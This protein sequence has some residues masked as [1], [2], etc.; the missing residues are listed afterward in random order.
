MTGAYTAAEERYTDVDAAY[1][2]LLQAADAARTVHDPQAARRATET[3]RGAE[4]RVVSRLTQVEEQVTE[5]ERRART[6]RD[7]A[8]ERGNIVRGTT[9]GD[10]VVVATGTLVTGEID[11]AYPHGGLQVRAERHYRSGT[12][13]TGSFGIWIWPFDSRIIRGV[14]PGIEE[15]ASEAS[16]ALA[17]IEEALERASEAAG[18]AFGENLLDAPQETLEG[19][20]ELV[21]SGR[22]LKAEAESAYREAEQSAD[23]AATLAASHADWSASP[24]YACLEE[25]ASELRRRIRGWTERLEDTEQ[26]AKETT[27]LLSALEGLLEEATVLTGTLRSAA[28]LSLVAREANRH[29]LFPADPVSLEETGAGTLVLVDET[30][31]PQLFRITS[32]PHPSSSEN[33]YPGGA[34]AEPVS[35]AL[36]GKEE[37]RIDPDGTYVRRRRDGTRFYYSRFGLLTAIEDRNGNALRLDRD[38]NM[39]VETLRDDVGRRVGV[40][41]ND[42]GMI[43]ALVDPA[44]HEVRYRY[45]A[46]GRLTEVT[47]AVGD[48]IVYEYDGAELRRIEK[49]DGSALRYRYRTIDGDRR[50]VA[51]VDEEGNEEHFYY[52]PQGQWTEYRNPSG[53]HTRYHYDDELRTT[54]TV[55]ADG[56]EK[57]RRFDRAGNVVEETDTRGN[58][59]V[60]DYDDAGYLTSE[61]DPHGG[62]YRLTYDE[63]GG[64]LSYRDAL[65]RTT[66]VERDSRGNILHIRYPHGFRQDYMY[67]QDGR[68]ARMSDSSGG[69]ST[70]RYD[71]L[72]YPARI[73]HGDGTTVRLAHDVFGRVVSH[74]DPTGITERRKYRP[75]GLLAE[76]AR[77][78]SSRA[79]DFDEGEAP[80]GS[81][82]DAGQDAGQGGAGD[83]HRISFEYDERKDRIARTGPRGFTTVY[84]YDRRHLLLEVRDAEGRS[85]RFRYRADRRLTE[86]SVAGEAT[87]QFAYDERGRRVSRLQVET[88]QEHRYAYDSAGNLRAETAGDGGVTSYRYSSTNRLVEI[89]DP[90]GSTRRFGYDAA[91]NLTTLT[92]ER[93]FR[94]RYRYDAT[95]RLRSVIDPLG[96]TSRIEYDDVERAVKVTDQMGASTL[97]RYDEHGRLQAQTDA[98]GSTLRLEYDAAGRLLRY[99]D[100]TG[101]VMNVRYDEY[102]R[103]TEIVDALGATHTFRHD[104]AGNLLERTDPRGHSRNYEYDALGRLVARTDE[105]GFETRFELDALGNRVAVH[106]PDG[107]TERRRFDAAGNCLAVSREGELHRSYEYD[108]AGRLITRT[109]AAGERWQVERDDAGR[110]IL[111]RSPGGT[112]TRYAYDEAGNLEAVIGP[113]GA[114]YRLRYDPLGNLT[115]EIN[116]V[117]AHARIRYDAAGRVR[118]RTGFDGAVRSYVHDALGRLSEVRHRGDCIAAYDYDPEGRLLLARNAAEELRFSYD[119]AGRMTESVAVAAGRRVEYEYD[120]AGN[121]VSLALQPDGE[122]YVYAHDGR[123]LVETLTLPNGDR[124]GF[125]YDELGREVQRRYPNGLFSDSTYDANGLIA[126][127]VHRSERRGVVGGEAYVRDPAGRI[128]FRVDTEGR[129]TDYE[130]DSE[131]RVSAVRYPFESV[132]SE[133]L[134]DGSRE[135]QQMLS[136]S[137]RELGSI[138]DVLDGTMPERKSLLSAVQP[139]WTER[140][141]HDELGNRLRK[142]TP[143]GVT[144]YRYDARQRLLEAGETAYDYDD[145]GRLTAISGTGAERRMELEYGVADRVVY[146]A[147][148]GNPADPADRPMHVHYR[149]D[150]LGRR[151]ERRVEAEEGATVSSAERGA[152]ARRYI[153]AGFDALPLA[154]VAIE[155]GSRSQLEASGESETG[156]VNGGRFRYLGD[157]YRRDIETVGLRRV[158]LTV[159]DRLLAEHEPAD[160]DV[161]Y[162]AVDVRGSVTAYLD[163]GEGKGERPVY[164]VFG[165]SSDERAAFAGNRL[166]PVTGF[167]DF[168]YRDYDPAVGRFTTPDP[169]KDGANWYAFV[170]GDP[171]NRV[172]PDGLYITVGPGVGYN[173]RTDRYQTSDARALKEKS[174]IEIVRNG[175][176]D[177]FYD[178]RMQLKVDG[179]VFSDTAVQS[180][181]DAAGHE[182]ATLPEGTYVGHLL[183]HSGSYDDPVLLENERLGVRAGQGN[184]IHPNEF[185]NPSRIA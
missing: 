20:S 25:E 4:E 149:Y 126:G 78:P 101:A 174:R 15:A 90:T 109:N 6:A 121:R 147:V 62:R 156:A 117:G 175:E 12:W 61:R 77:V 163:G 173:E 120:A 40:R 53:I 180:E 106:H 28:R 146:A 81:S 44:G 87:E 3:A 32:E 112:V 21:A 54:R 154:S 131:G 5:V 95:D 130:Y 10:P 30:G 111:H 67:L 85:T 99:R 104:K 127:I 31:T 55:Y 136:L 166:D 150:A 58:T 138:R 64:L 79:A 37:L 140:L 159:G 181:A 43:E 26:Y 52:D 75:D 74:T 63:F 92:D 22:A 2:E 125:S 183:D 60:R 48:R 137:G 91:G 72:G 57:R 29:A 124:V 84:R 56:T 129:V 176:T 144:E 170:D 142:E 132:E 169:L 89:T 47:D 168:G 93:G 143:A 119:A 27:R 145:A 8:V 148:L 51:T 46:T 162:A 18:E 9:A 177:E 100:R 13:P 24:R 7:E 153:H 49:P 102:G 23:T 172:D 113:D 70:F 157:R 158:H 50:V 182:D 184:L 97:S 164:D 152:P 122:R 114:A 139:V 141:V 116:R 39:Y 42:R 1:D 17:G 35:P 14:T 118:E 179:I 38:E 82:S 107:T 36:R 110:I 45:D 160:G 115:E 65:G 103:P 19:F 41:R 33:P 133:L 59:W 98:L 185:T 155:T 86:R 105:E 94:W 80:L 135:L 123:G 165:S 69:E 88:G 96:G 66:E 83:A 16:E 73:R 134:V 151:V 34:S 71:R 68:L 76:I 161:H 128:R 167:Y 171:V 11:F 108:D 178:D